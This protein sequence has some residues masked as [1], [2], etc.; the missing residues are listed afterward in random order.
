M[1]FLNA[2]EAWRPDAKRIEKA[3]SDPT[4]HG[5]TSKGTLGTTPH[6]REHLGRQLALR[7]IAI[8]QDPARLGEAVSLM[9]KALNEAPELNREY[10]ARLRLWRRGISM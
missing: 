9:E 5:N 7:S 3:K 4:S 8:A 10:E 6:A 2:L 1:E